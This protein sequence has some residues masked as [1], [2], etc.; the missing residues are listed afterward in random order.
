M[1]PEVIYRI[2]AIPI[3]IPRILFRRIEEKILKFTW[4]RF[5]KDLFRI[6]TDSVRRFCTAKAILRSKNKV[7]DITHPHFKLHYKAI[8]IKKQQ[9]HIHRSMQQNRNHRN[10]PPQTWTINLQQ[11]KKNIQWGKDSLF[12]KW[13]ENDSHMQTKMK[14]GVCLTLD[15]K[16][17]SD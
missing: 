11:R 4:N 9:Q 7:G 8:V 5:C 6:F 3:K 2:N 1:L 13:L 12:N 14:L 16:I 15:T 10:K 17:N